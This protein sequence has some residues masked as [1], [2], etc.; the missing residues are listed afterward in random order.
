MPDCLDSTDF[1]QLNVIS[2]IQEQGTPWTETEL[3]LLV[4]GVQTFKDA[5][6]RVAHHVGSRTAQ[7]CLETFLALDL[8]SSLPPP[9]PSPAYTQQSTDTMLHPDIA[10]SLLDPVPPT[11]PSESSKHL[12]EKLQKTLK[13]LPFKPADNPLMAL[14]AVLSTLSDDPTN[15][16]F[17]KSVVGKHV[18]AV[19]SRRAAFEK[20][21]DGISTHVLRPST[22]VV[23]DPAK[24]NGTDAHHKPP[25]PAFTTEEIEAVKG[26]FMDIKKSELLYSKMGLSLAF[27]LEAERVL[28]RERAEFVKERRV[29]AMDWALLRREVSEFVGE[30][31]ERIEKGWNGTGG[32]GEGEGEGEGDGGSGVGSEGEVESAVGMDGA[33]VAAVDGNGSA[34]F[35]AAESVEGSLGLSEDEQ[36]GVNADDG[37]GEQGSVEAISDGNKMEVD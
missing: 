13:R 9:Q 24:T 14:A 35:G 17:Y 2:T 23:S 22:V 15:E 19:N 6:T 10:N 12:A 27:Y 5:W 3:F 31:K 8:Y 11:Y 30:V 36:E 7:D 29:L 1:I 25:Q 16:S 26:A 28:E 37:G 21:R 20:R 34:G 4:D 33:S 18:G 32:E